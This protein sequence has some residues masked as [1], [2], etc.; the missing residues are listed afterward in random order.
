MHVLFTRFPLESRFGGAE[1]Q[2]LNVMKGLLERGH[3]VRFVGSC[4]TLLQ[5]IGNKR[6]EVV[7]K[8]LDIGPPPVTKWGV[9]S[10][11]WRKGEMK[12]KLISALEQ[13]LTRPNGH[14]AGRAAYRYFH[15]LAHRKAAAHP[16]VQ[17]T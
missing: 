14:L 9:I 11:V 8:K 15:A 16:M 13:E 17:R 7:V 12:K 1:V 5:A 6:R 10:F 2:T 4:P 3:E